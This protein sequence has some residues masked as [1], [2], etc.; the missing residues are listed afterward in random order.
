MLHALKYLTLKVEALE[1]QVAE[2]V[3]LASEVDTETEYT[4]ASD[5]TLS[6]ITDAS[7]EMSD[8]SVQ[9]APF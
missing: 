2:L 1:K 4:I 8:E 3:A 6:I 9:S 5:S 7:D